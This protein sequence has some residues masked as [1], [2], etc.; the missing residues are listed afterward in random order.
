[1]LTCITNFEGIPHT[2][3]CCECAQEI[4]PTID[5]QLESRIPTLR[6]RIGTGGPIRV[7]DLQ[8]T[9]VDDVLTGRIVDAL[10]N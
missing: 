1:M 6:I 10:V 5:S 4:S 7:A 9:I 2:P 8:C 3:A